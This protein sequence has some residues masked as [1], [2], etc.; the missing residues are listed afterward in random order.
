MIKLSGKELENAL[1]IVNAQAKR[2]NAQSFEA[3]EVLA[4]L[5]KNGSIKSDN[6]LLAKLN[7]KYPSDAV[8]TGVAVRFRKELA[9]EGLYIV[10]SGR[11]PTTYTLKTIPGIPMPQTPTPSTGAGATQTPAKVGN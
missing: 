2:G 10:A 11:R 5:R 1:A 7:P 9:E 6:P 8:W 3:S 4:H